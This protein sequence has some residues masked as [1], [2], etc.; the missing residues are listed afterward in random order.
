MLILKHTDSNISEEIEINTVTTGH[1]EVSKRLKCSTNDKYHEH[2]T[3]QRGCSRELTSSL[4]QKVC[5]P[6]QATNYDVLKDSLK[7]R[8]PTGTKK[9]VS[10]SAVK[11]VTR[12]KPLKTC[13]KKPIVPTAELEMSE[14]D[15]DS[16][17]KR[18]MYRKTSDVASK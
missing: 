5:Q 2:T 16:I 18:R 7:I 13:K 1:S 4:K 6:T 12:K 11:L 15:Q 9:G 8:P 3:V 14:Q 17:W 10:T